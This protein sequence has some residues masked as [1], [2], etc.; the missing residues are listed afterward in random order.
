MYLSDEIPGKN[1]N[2]ILTTFLWNILRAQPSS[3]VTMITMITL[4][5][6]LLRS[7]LESL[8]HI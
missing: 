2:N 5:Q 1:S 3:L 7:S 6:N 8:A 4:K